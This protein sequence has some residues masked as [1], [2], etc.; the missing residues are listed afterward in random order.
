MIRGQK[1]GV[2]HLKTD[3]IDLHMHSTVSDGT[4]T[5][6]RLTEKVRNADIKIFSVTDHDAV[7]TGRMIRA[8]LADKDPLFIPGVEFSCRD[9]GGKYHILGYG[10]DPED[11]GIQAVVEHGHSLRMKKAAARIDFLKTEFGFCFPQEEVEGLLALDN[12]GKPHIGNLMVKYGFADTKE[13]AIHEYI[14]Q[15]H[16][17]SEYI[18]PQE[19]IGGI[20]ASGGIPVLAHPFYGSG[21]EL[22][23]GEEMKRRIEHL[24]PFGLRGIEAYYSGFSDKLRQEALSLAETYDLLVTAGSD[25]HGTNKMVKLGDTGLDGQTPYPERLQRFLELVTR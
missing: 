10:F 18:R 11:D 16:F 3:K 20:L 2:T 21:D 7:K 9:E 14:D 23:L 25:Y 4:D 19:A 24:L 8:L 17:K 13:N 12:P 22:I 15:I 6:D 5:P 1:E